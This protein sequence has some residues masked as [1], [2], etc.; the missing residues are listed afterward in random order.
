[1]SAMADERKN[2]FT[3]VELLALLAIIGGLLAILLPA[4]QAART[5][6]RRT[7]RINELKNIGLSL[8]NFHDC[9]R[10]FP[11]AIRRDAVGRPLASWRYQILPFVAGWMMDIDYAKAWC[12][13]EG[14]YFLL[15]P[16]EPYCFSQHQ[17]GEASFNT[18]VAGIVGPG[19]VFDERRVNI[20]A[21]F[22]GHTIMAIEVAE[23]DRHWMEPDDLS[24][25]DLPDSLMS[26]T[27]GLGVLAV[28][29]DGS[30]VFV[31]GSEPVEELKKFMTADDIEA[32]RTDLFLK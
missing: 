12:D 32:R 19:T 30:A 20:A 22:D 29:V 25:A 4:V 5:A 18:N 26:G 10:R 11:P 3:V 2:R 15:M 23:F 13:P 6:A 8:Q 27:D 31:G 21:D 1:M 7:Q 16:L 17:R 24:L 9:Y 28:C 14:K